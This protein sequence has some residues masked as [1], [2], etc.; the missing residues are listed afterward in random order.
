MP[1]PSSNE[2]TCYISKIGSFLRDTNLDE[3]PQLWNVLK[4]DMSIVGPRPE[5]PFHVANYDEVQRDRL[6]V[7][8]GLTGMWQISPDRNKEIHDNIDYDLYYINNMS[9]FVDLIL[10]VETLLLTLAAVAN[11]VRSFLFGAFSLKANSASSQNK[12]GSLANPL[13]GELKAPT[14]KR[15]LP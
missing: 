7:K 14:P 13:Q 10:V 6:K 15:A 5:M 11:K 8:P 1:S 12:E 3:T 2:P 4:G 9:F